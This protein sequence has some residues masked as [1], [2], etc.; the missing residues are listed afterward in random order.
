MQNKY[1]DTANKTPPIFPKCLVNIFAAEI[2]PFSLQNPLVS[3]AKAVNVEIMPVSTK[4]SKIPRLAESN[5][6]AFLSAEYAIGEL[7]CPASCEKRPFDMPCLTA[8]DTKNPKMP[9][10]AVLLLNAQE[11]MLTIDDG[12]TLMFFIITKIVIKIYNIETNGTAND[13]VFLIKLPS[14][15]A[16]INIGIPIKMAHTA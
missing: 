12:K 5:E 15:K 11:N 16:R 8:V 1:I 14:E 6:F 4:T 3:I 10:T 7:P 2:I 13:D 9:D